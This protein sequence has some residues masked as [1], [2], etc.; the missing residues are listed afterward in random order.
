MAGSIMLNLRLPGQ[1]F[2]AETGWHQNGFRDYVPSFGRYL[3]S[4]PIGFAGGD[5]N[6]YV[7]LSN[8][9]LNGI[10]PLG[11]AGGFN[12]SPLQGVEQFVSP[13]TMQSRVGELLRQHIADWAKW[14]Q[15]SEGASRFVRA[16]NTATGKAAWNA[17]LK[18]T[19]RPCPNGL[20]TVGIRPS[21]IVG[22]GLG[23][24]GSLVGLAPLTVPFEE[25]G[26][27][28]GEWLSTDPFGVS[29]IDTPDWW[30][31]H[32]NAIMGNRSEN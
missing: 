11:L 7:Y 29:T 8:D 13:E 32:W 10:D 19:P 30:S 15:L 23:G 3:E 26:I 2:E 4:D 31:N 16:Q 9:P 21:P 17:L 27:K 1:Y 28:F 24:W 18:L 20:G 5:P 22:P 6:L 25:S 14:R 12:F